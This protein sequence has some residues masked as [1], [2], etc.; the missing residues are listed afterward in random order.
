MRIS[1]DKFDPVNLKQ[2]LIS[3]SMVAPV[4]LLAIFLGGPVYYAMIIAATIIGALEWINI[5]APKTSI[6][7]RGC[8]AGSIFISIFVG[9]AISPMSGLI[10]GL[11]FSPAL[12][13]LASREDMERAGWVALALPYLAG[14]GLALLSSRAIPEIGMAMTI[15]LV[16]VVWAADV[17]GFM[18]GNMIGGSKLM[19]SVS[20]NKTWAGFGGGV[21]LAAVFGCVIAVSFGAKEPISAFITAVLI[22]VVAQVGDLFE[23]YV[24]RRNDVKDSGNIMPG[25]GGILD[26]IDGLLFASIFFAVFRLGQ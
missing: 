18:A 22:A 4:V 6:F 25:H 10:I 11:L 21:V 8:T 5:V 16:V 20:P 14:G 1:L 13:F 3:A 12:L 26:R 9:A 19:P 15:Y 7:I 17:G 2:R 24:K 23:S